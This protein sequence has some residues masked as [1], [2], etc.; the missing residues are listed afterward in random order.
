M[1]CGGATTPQS[2]LDK[3]KPVLA[4]ATIINA[5]ASSG[6][7]VL[8]AISADAGQLQVINQLNWDE[9]CSASLVER[10][11]ETILTPVFYCA[12]KYLASAQQAPVDFLHPTGD[13]WGDA[14][15]APVLNWCQGVESSNSKRVCCRFASARPDVLDV[16]EEQK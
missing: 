5:P 8:I 11:P 1:V 15:E 3:I 16:Y 4:G 6:R 7:A 13:T 10:L 2:V 9:T 14:G 12:C